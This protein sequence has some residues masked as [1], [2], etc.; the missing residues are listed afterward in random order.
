LYLRGGVRRTAPPPELVKAVAT[1][2]RANGN[3]D[4]DRVASQCNVTARK[5]QRLFREHV[6]LPPKVLA[7]IFRF[8]HIFRVAESAC[9][10]EWT[11]VAL[12]CGYVD[13]AHLIR[14]FRDF[15]GQTPAALLRAESDLA[16][17]FLRARRVSHF[18]NPRAAAVGDYLGRRNS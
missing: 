13:Q 8:Q 4:I 14:D 9:P 18:S 1:L 5:L 10:T 15:A 3:I 6:G 12:E 17:V 16:E 7:R 11:Q 2:R